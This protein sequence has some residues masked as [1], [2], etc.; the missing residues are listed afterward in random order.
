[1]PTWKHIRAI[2]ALPFMATIVIPGAITAL[3]GAVHVGWSLPLP[4]GLVPPLVGAALI[5]IG[6]IILVRT[7]A[8]FATLGEGTLAPWDPTRRL[9]VRGVYR[10]VRNPMIS[11]VFCILLGEAALVG[12]IPLLVWFAGFVLVNLVYTP[13]VE[14]LDL[15]RRFGEDYLLYKEHVPRWIPRLKP[16]DGSFGGEQGT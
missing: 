13:L 7:V 16:W 6:L 15:A 10:H 8:M 9:V 1:M 4:L 12:S 11:G 14:E 5:G 2:A 3:T